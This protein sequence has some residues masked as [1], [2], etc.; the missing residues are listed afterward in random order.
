MGV[1]D[2]NDGVHIAGVSIEVDEHDGFGA[3]GDG[4]FYFVGVYIEI[5]GI[6]IDEDGCCADV[7]DG[8][9]GC[10]EGEGGGNDFVAGF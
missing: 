2:I 6:D 3:L 8:P 5:E 7:G 9:G 1:A 10:G 4:G